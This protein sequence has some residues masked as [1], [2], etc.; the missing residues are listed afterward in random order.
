MKP[1]RPASPV[2]AANFME[3][4]KMM[5]KTIAMDLGLISFAQ[6]MEV[7]DAFVARKVADPDLPDLILLCEHPPVFTLGRRGGREFLR[8]SEAFLAEKGVGVEACGRGGLI[9]YHGPGQLVAYPV[10]NL[11]RRGLGV[12][13]FVEGLEAAMVETVA[14]CGIGASGNPAARGLWVASRKMGSI[15]IAV[16]RQVSFHGIAINLDLD[17]TPFSWISPCG[18]SIAM[19]SVEKERGAAVSMGQLQTDFLRAM[20]TVMACRVVRETVAAVWDRCGM[21]PVA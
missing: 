4:G 6:A 13:S 9:T 2:C 15:G 3:K 7:Q 21:L 20:E 12:R 17:L 5:P 8:V 11:Q 16:H 10:W 1:Q 14:C 18:L 19:T